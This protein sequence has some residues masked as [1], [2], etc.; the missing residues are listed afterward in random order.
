[1]R[2]W[3]AS[4]LLAIAPSTGK[5]VAQTA[6]PAA[7][8]KP[9]FEVAAIKANTNTSDPLQAKGGFLPGGRV[10]L[11]NITVQQ[12]IMGAYS[13][14]ADM[15]V[16]APKWVETDRFDIVAK[17][18]QD[19]PE[20]TLFLMVQS[21]LEDRFKLAIHREPKLAPV[22][23]LVAAKNG[24]KLQTPTAPGKSGCSWTPAQ[25]GLRHRDCHNV[26]IAQ[27][28]S[29]LP[30]MGGAGIDRPVV[31][32]TQL[33]GAYDFQFAFRPQ[34]GPM[35]AQVSTAERPADDSGPTIFDA[36]AQIGLK[37]EPRKQAVQTIVIDHVER[38]PTD[39]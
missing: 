6:Q 3:F 17:A 38:T 31:D 30:G 35:G 1:M 21:L 23:V 27:L 37:L 34:R 8:P 9:S 15:I 33:T 39:N 20:P 24:P 22:F 19:T 16:G 26:S 5:V 29:Q 32:E 7:T 36:M 2:H 14:Q 10:E 25:D 12:C 28:V 13:V 11:H 4:L 18:P